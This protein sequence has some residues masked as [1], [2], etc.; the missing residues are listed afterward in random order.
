MASLK[1]TQTEINIMK[2][3]AGESQARNRYTYFASKAKNDGL[4]QISNIFEE[5]A[6]Q[7]REH[8]KRL[9]KMLEGG[10]TE[11]TASFPSGVIGS[12]A[13]NLTEGAAGEKRRTL[14]SG[15]AQS[16]G[17]GFRRPAKTFG[18]SPSGAAPSDA[19]LVYLRPYNQALSSQ[20]EQPV[21]WSLSVTCGKSPTAWRR[22]AS[23]RPALT[24]SSFRA[25]GGELVGGLTTYCCCVIT[26]TRALLIPVMTEER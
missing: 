1:G 9:F 21:A 14:V 3:F 18:P 15:F 19:T 26:W 12:T 23:A 17:R 6:N 25:I 16:L 22:R 10:T 4:V 7:E 11:I 24:K 13:E 2:A 8:A 5:T 20:K